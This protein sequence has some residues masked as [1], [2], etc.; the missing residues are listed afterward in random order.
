MAGDGLCTL[1]GS[2]SVM[3]ATPGLLYPAL[4]LPAGRAE[5]C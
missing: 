5:S 4:E 2:S 3:A 1:D